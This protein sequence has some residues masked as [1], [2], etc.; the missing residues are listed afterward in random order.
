MDHDLVEE[1][2]RYLTRIQHTFVRGFNEEQ[3]DNSIGNMIEND[4]WLM[5]NVDNPM[6]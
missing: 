2:R 5:M 1:S 4:G 6:P 3:W